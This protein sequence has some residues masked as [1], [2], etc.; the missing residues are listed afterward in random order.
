M[1]DTLERLRQERL[2]RESEERQRVAVLKGQ[3]LPGIAARAANDSARP[4]GRYFAQFNPQLARPARP[5]GPPTRYS[6]KYRVPLPPPASTGA[7]PAP[8]R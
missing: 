5:A 6:D 3:P 8:P 1:S 4:V 2:L 7:A